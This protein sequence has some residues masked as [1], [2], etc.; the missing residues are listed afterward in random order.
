MVSLSFESDRFSPADFLN[1]TVAKHISDRIIKIQMSLG[2]ALVFDGIVDIQ[3]QVI[4][5]NGHFTNF[6]CRRKTCLLLDNEVKPYWYFNLTSDQIIKTHA[7][8]YGVVGADL[9]KKAMLPQVLA[10]KGISHW[11][12]ITLFC[13]LA[14]K[15]S[16]YVNREG[17]LTCEPFQKIEHRFS[18]GRSDGIPFV[19]AKLTDDRYQMLSKVWVKTGKAEYGA[20]YQYV[21]SN[22]SATKLGIV[23]ERYYHPELEWNGEPS[24]AAKQYYED[25]Q[26]GFFEIEVTV[27]GLFDIRAGDSAR[28]DDPSGSYYNLYVTKVSLLSNSEGNVTK[29]ILWEKQG[30]IN[31]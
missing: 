7:L 8:P 23:R 28:F 30:L 3:K 31:Q 14:Y 4:G 29:V 1:F 15:K 6:V 18:N 17:I 25:K 16:P 9:P 13:R 24:L 10:K 5:Q 12:F 21:L 19:E 2:S 11:E 20:S 26:A 27:P 22:P